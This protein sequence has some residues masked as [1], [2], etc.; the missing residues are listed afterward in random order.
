M[1]EKQPL[2][3]RKAPTYV[4]N[5]LD[6]DFP[7][8]QTESS[9]YLDRDY[10]I[11]ILDKSALLSYPEIIPSHDLTKK[12][13]TKDP[14]QQLDLCHS[15][16]VIPE[17]VVSE[18][19]AV[20]KTEGLEYY[21]AKTALKRI[22][23]LLCNVNFSS[24]TNN[25]AGFR[26]AIFFPDEDILFTVFQN[27][28]GHSPK[29]ELSPKDPIGRLISSVSLIIESFKTVTGKDTAFSKK[30]EKVE[31]LDKIT[32]LTSDHNV[33]VFARINGIKVEEFR[34]CT[35]IY[36]GRR[37][38]SVPFE[39]YFKFLES[40][41]GISLDDWGKYLEEEP[42][43][44]ANEFIHMTPILKNEDV[45]VLTQSYTRFR[46]I[47]R[48]D[49]A[50]NRI[51]HLTHFHRFGI[52]PMNAG[53]AMYAE[54]IAHPDIEIVIATGKSGT[55][56]TL[57]S[58][59]G[60]MET[61]D[62][63]PFIRVVAIPCAVDVQKKLGCMPGGMAEKLAPNTQP[64]RNAL[65]NY[66]ALLDSKNS[67]T[68]TQTPSTNPDEKYVDPE[69]N[70]NDV[71]SSSKKKKKATPAPISSEKQAEA[72]MRAINAKVNRAM[73][74]TISFHPVEGSRGLDFTSCYV[75]YDEF[76]DNDPEAAKTLISRLGDHSKTII[77]GD[78]E[79]VHLESVTEKNNG[80]VFVKRYATGI[81]SVAQ[82]HLTV[83][84]VV[85]GGF[86]KEFLKRLQEDIG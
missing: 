21:A 61:H 70:I 40:D 82:I 62:N 38:I 12:L 9:K 49:Q 83:D 28:R 57:F 29:V 64:I 6:Y 7:K 11:Y 69:S 51:V 27:L 3:I 85:R 31:W 58:V 20:N 36:T 30:S 1:K 35:P 50:S 68:S 39:L 24:N 25:G 15:H 77:T 46:N 44:I 2:P 74:H 26:S 63:N 41:T 52:A 18:L 43:L 22:F 72:K 65:W 80:I 19:I 14:K 78:I 59:A 76:Q 67:A 13:E 45:D 55:G 16:L 54:A 75:I 53:Q 84:D 47:G 23:R 73:N 17:S 56:K 86:L 4:G 42:E 37:N 79:Q 8:G 60:A 5:I 66:F 10:P 32:L 48:F 71:S 33:N 34:W 81:N